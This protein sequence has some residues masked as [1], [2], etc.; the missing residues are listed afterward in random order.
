MCVGHVYY[1]SAILLLLFSLVAV[2]VV[3]LVSG[4]TILLHWVFKIKLF[5]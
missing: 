3:F 1:H 4:S 2:H 5:E